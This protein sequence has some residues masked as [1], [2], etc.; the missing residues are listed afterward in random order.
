LKILTNFEPEEEWVLEP[1]DMLYLP[2]RWA[3]DG[4]AEGGECMTCSIGFRVPEATELAREV[5]IR[6][7][8]GMESPEK[9]Q[10]YKDPG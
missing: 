10:L 2:P 5:L 4:I 8:E 3:H 9:P 7:M 6:W 1:G